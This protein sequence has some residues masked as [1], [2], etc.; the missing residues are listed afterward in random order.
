MTR[1]LSWEGGDL[2]ASKLDLE[3][4]GGQEG[5]TG[6]VTPGRGCSVYTGQDMEQGGECAEAWAGDD[7]EPVGSCQGKGTGFSSEAVVL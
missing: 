4:Q 2:R 5:G 1:K 6:D 3:G 7:E